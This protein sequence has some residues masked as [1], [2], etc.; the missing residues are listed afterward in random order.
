MYCIPAEEAL[1]FCIYFNSVWK[2]LEGS[3]LI[4]HLENEDRDALVKIFVRKS[5]ERFEVEKD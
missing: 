4:F 3:I 5:S 2:T 1:H